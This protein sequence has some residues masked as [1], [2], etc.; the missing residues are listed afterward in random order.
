[1]NLLIRAGSDITHKNEV[2][3]SALHRAVSRSDN[4][5]MIEPLLMAGININ[6]QDKYGA[7]PF[8]VA[9]CR[10][11]LNSLGLL[12]DHGA[13]VDVENSDG[14][15]ALMSAIFWQYERVTQFLLEHGVNHTL[16]N[17]AGQTI[18]HYIAMYG[19]LKLLALFQDARL[20]GLETEILD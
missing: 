11:Q 13:D 9:V 8:I 20:N 4:L 6:E 1:M 15:V 14:D 18:L 7:T 10:N 16:R 17:K 5:E 2:Q 19:N 12:L 3:N